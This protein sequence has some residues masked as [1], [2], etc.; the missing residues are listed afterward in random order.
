MKPIVIIGP[1]TSQLR[2]SVEAVTGRVVV[3]CPVCGATGTSSETGLH[4][5][6]AIVEHEP[7]CEW[8]ATLAKS[9]T[10]RKDGSHE[11]IH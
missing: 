11:S 4:H 10:N 7:N 3:T 1:G 6:S 2:Y 5:I 9:V 8:L